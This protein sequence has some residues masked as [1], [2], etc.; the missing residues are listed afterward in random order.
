MPETV[1]S[2]Q[3]EYSDRGQE[4]V[5]RRLRDLRSEALGAAKEVN[6]LAVSGGVGAQGMSALSGSLG[7]VTGLLSVFGVAV[8]ARAALKFSMDAMEMAHASEQARVTLDALTGSAGRSAEMIE[9]VQRALRGAISE[10]DA[11]RVAGKLLSLGLA[12]NAQEAERFAYAAATLGKAFRNLDPGESVELFNRM[13]SNRSVRL[14]DDFGIGIAEVNKRLRELGDTSTEAFQT[15]VMEIAAEKAAELGDVWDTSATTMDRL[16]AKTQ[17]YKAE[18]GRLVSE[19][20]VPAAE[21]ALALVEGLESVV[22]ATLE[23]Q[24]AIGDNARTVEEY[25]EALDEAHPA[26]KLLTAAQ[27]IF[28]NVTEDS[29]T[30]F[31]KFLLLTVPAVPIFHRLGAAFYETAFSLDALTETEFR[32]IKA[33]GVHAA[34]IGRVKNQMAQFEHAIRMA[35]EAQGEELTAAEELAQAYVDGLITTE[36]YQAGKL[37]LMDV[38]QLAAQKEREEAEAVREAERAHRE[39]TQALRDS[40][41]L[42]QDMTEVARDMAGNYNYVGRTVRVTTAANEG[43]ADQLSYIRNEQEQVNRGLFEAQ[44]NVAIYGEGAGTASERMADLTTQQQAWRN[45][46]EQTDAQGLGDQTAY[47]ARQVQNLDNQIMAVQMNQAA[48]G[49]GM[50]ANAER[51]TELSQQQEILEAAYARTAEA[52]GEVTRAVV[53]SRLSLED[54]Q[55]VGEG[56]LKIFELYGHELGLQGKALDDYMLRWGLVTQQQLTYRGVVEDVMESVENNSITLRDAEDIIAG[57][58]TGVLTSTDA[59]NDAIEVAENEERIRQDLIAQTETLSEKYDHMAGRATAGAD[60]SE[61]AGTRQQAALTAVETRAG[62]VALAVEESFGLMSDS[63]NA[64]I[65]AVN[66]LNT[67]LEVL[68]G[69]LRNIKANSNITITTTHI[70]VEGELQHGGPALGGHPYIVGEA[71]PELFVPSQSGFVVPN[72]QLGGGGI[73]SASITVNV[74]G[75]LDLSDPMSADRFATRAAPAIMRELQARAA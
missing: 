41:K 50:G 26:V 16:T 7:A 4:Q 56:I 55:A 31:E 27:R 33:K 49:D 12:E 70:S 21:G 37:A 15:V 18:L 59:V 53:I 36:E 39:Y 52:M 44:M 20:L 3:L 75:I 40:L 62:E 13:L 63:A 51:V 67:R 46:L 60:T 23:A 54:Q 47:A 35:T 5:L 6:Q 68:L 38:T 43:Y 2:A 28:A 30:G 73:G 11:A 45:V 72:H 17:D 74:T 57:Y 71:G 25:R 32:A 10:A 34:E 19:A 8:S 58:T 66:R 9:A 42:Q 48:F 1:A 69:T 22:D 61:D 29:L 24:K 65:P 64:S 14:L